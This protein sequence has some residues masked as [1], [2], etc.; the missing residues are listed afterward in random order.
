MALAALA[1]ACGLTP[2]SRSPGVVP[3]ETSVQ[4][5]WWTWAYSADDDASPVQ[6][7]TGEFCDHAQPDDL[8]FLAGTYGG[9]VRRSCRIPAGRPLAFPLVN[10]LGDAADCATFM[11]TAKGKAVLDGKPV[12]PERL[13]EAGVTVTDSAGTGT[14]H[15]CG[16]WVRLA[17]LP[18]GPHTLTIR[19]SSGTFRTGVD[20]RLVVE[21]APQA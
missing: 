7:T 11:A 10:L 8:W 16:L 2:E 17:P 20:Y 12:E 14:T 5:R 21:P 4:G 6:D 15:A 19:G 3:P 1:P 9:T 13:D 18:T